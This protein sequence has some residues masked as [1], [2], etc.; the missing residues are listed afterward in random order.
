MKIV[1]LSLRV[2]LPLAPRQPTPKSSQHSERFTYIDALR[3]VAASWVLL[4]HFA[5]HLT[6]NFALQRL[7]GPLHSF[8]NHG[9]LGV[10][11]FFVLS[12]FVITYSLRD[13][14]VTPGFLGRFALRRS[15]RLDPPYWVTILLAYILIRLGVG[16][17][18]P[19]PACG[20]GA[21]LLVNMFYLDRILDYPSVVGIGWT[22][23]LEIQLYLTYIL[24]LGIS[25]QLT[26]KTGSPAQ[27][28]LLIFGPLAGYSLAVGFG[29]LP[30]P[31][32]GLFV[33]YWYMFF[34][35]SLA[36]WL[37]CGQLSMRGFATAGL[38]VALATVLHWDVRAAVALAVALSIMVV[39]RSGC[40]R[41]A[42][43]WPWL[44][45]LGR[46][47]YSLYLTHTLIGWPLIALGIY[48][49][50]GLPGPLG[51][52]LLFLTA[53]GASLL[54]AELL[55][56]LVERPSLALSKRVAAWRPSLV[57]FP[58]GAQYDEKRTAPAS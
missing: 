18:A 4:Y 14:A 12:G 3:G 23:C 11:I 41:T 27:S 47:S 37:L 36:A 38:I 56:R 13:A 24:L 15:L 1:P 57:G 29:L 9:W 51:S 32:R 49:V 52:I 31:W 34:L 35:G 48:W 5:G 7:P 10:E 39:G 26:Q 8:I 21:L 45:H 43:N 54:G 6:D 40:L 33:G 19:E 58:C 16:A 28:R 55:H 2:L 50:G 42:L 22:L 44:Q 46:I 30:S 17:L 25:Q 20:D 53:C